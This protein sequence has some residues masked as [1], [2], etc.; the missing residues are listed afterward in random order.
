M[1]AEALHWATAAAEQGSAFA[2]YLIGWIRSDPQ[3]GMRDLEAA[4]TTL[5]EAIEHKDCPLTE[6][7]LTASG[8]QA[9]AEMLMAVDTELIENAPSEGARRMERLCAFGDYFDIFER[10]NWEKSKL[11]AEEIKRIRAMYAF[12]RLDS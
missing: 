10:P 8:L 5:R 9:A 12:E 1:P 6:G 2:M 3:F 11:S 4:R 7:G